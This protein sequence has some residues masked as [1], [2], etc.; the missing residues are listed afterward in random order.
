[1]KETMRETDEVG[2]KSAVYANEALTLV[3]PRRTAYGRAEGSREADRQLAAIVN[4]SRDAIWSWKP[5][6]TIVS[7]NAEAERLFGYS[8]D[9][10]IGKSLFTLI[11]P[12]HH[13]RARVA[14][15]RLG[16]GNWYGQF[17]TERASKSGK[18][19]PVELTISPIFDES[20][21]TIELATICRDI[22]N[23]YNAE[24]AR[25]QLAAIISS[26][27]DA[28]VAKDLDGIITTWNEGAER[29][30]GYEAEEIVGKSIITIIPPERQDEEA[31]ILERIRRGERVEPFDTLRQRKDGSLV[32]VSITISPVKDA[33]GRIVG[34]SKIARDITD[35]KEAERVREFLT[36]ELDHR[37][38]NILSIVQAIANQTFMHVPEA[39][40]ALKSFADRLGAL[41]AAH[42]L[43][44]RQNWQD[45]PL[46]ELVKAVIESAG[47]GERVQTDG[48][49]ATLEARAA[50][51]LGLALHELCTNAI[52]YGALSNQTGTVAVT[53][54]VAD[55]A[56]PELTLTW[57][58]RGGPPVSPPQ[59][60]GFG[61]LMLR[62][63][64]TRPFGEVSLDFRPEGLVCVVRLALHTANREA[65]PA[66]E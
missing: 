55:G 58:E 61:A 57:E 12:D 10:I 33:L 40:E 15:E 23:R 2:A 65:A 16:D 62:R 39:S 9:E 64:I 42:N 24:Q 21:N 30:F 35:R 47:Q 44:M 45:A 29:L 53:W 18:V 5:D 34:A 27:E 48:P 4:A 19:I 50:V 22:T 6:G 13:E 20:G 11:P 32:D 7:W 26:S 54:D 14:I 43:L 56:D 51:L 17:E 46:M 66:A 37:V 36:R 31:R 1:M 49:H 8:A 28:I 63:M 25:Q 59:Q 38:K 52:K 60:H 3:S 41:S